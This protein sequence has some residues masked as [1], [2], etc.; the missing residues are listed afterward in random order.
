KAR[1]ENVQ[2]YVLFPVWSSGFTNPQNTD[3]DAAFYEKE[4]EFKGRKPESE[5][6]ISLSSSAQSKKHDDK[7]K[8][9]AKGNSHVESS[10]GYRNLSAEFEDFSDNNINEDNVAGKYSYVD[11]SK[12]HDDPNMPELEDITYSD[13]EED[14]GAEADITNLGTTITV[15]PIPTTRVHKDHP[16]SQIIGDLSSATQTRSMSLMAKDQGGLSQINND[17]LHTCMFTC[18]LS[19]EEPKSVHQALKDPSWIEVMQEELLQFKVQK[20]WV[21]VDLPQEKRAIDQMVSGKDSSNSLMA[22]NLPK[23]IWYSTHHVAL[24]KS[25]LV[26]KQTALVL[27]KTVNDVPRLQALVN[28]KKVIITEATIRDSLRLANTEGIDCLPNEQVDEGAVKVNVEDVS[29]TG[30][31]AEG[32][33]SVAD[34]EVPT[35]VNELSIPSPIPP[36]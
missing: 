35:A 19:Q 4:P 6:N 22:D 1:E 12:L 14:V 30:V 20:V 36:T 32:A 10:T 31:V 33:A 3:G 7:T 9:E 26:Q 11:S 15:S 17:D 24:M 23:I 27:V 2:Q 13:D 16:V 18:F 29:T 25:W 21:L 8:R 5:V 34:D 28:K